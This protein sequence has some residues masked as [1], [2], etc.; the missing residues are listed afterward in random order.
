MQFGL[1]RQSLLRKPQGAPP[2]SDGL[3]EPGAGIV[4]HVPDD[5]EAQTMRLETIG[6]TML[7]QR[8]R[9]NG[10]TMANFDEEV[11]RV[12]ESEQERI[13]AEAKYGAGWVI[14]MTGLVWLFVA[15]LL[16][17]H[18]IQSASSGARFPWRELWA[19]LGTFAVVSAVAWAYH[20][21]NSSRKMRSARLIR[22]ELKLDK[23]L[24][25][26][27]EHLRQHIT[28]ECESVREQVRYRRAED[29]AG[30]LAAVKASAKRAGE[31]D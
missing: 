16:V 25:E 29:R 18:A 7:A 24:E 3:A 31:R 9:R 13:A 26:V 14:L 28:D 12:L 22:I 6:I 2:S 19:D 8:F 23:L 15:G 20:R 27:P 11:K 1:F 30:L 4:F 5:P 21:L 10:K 17:W